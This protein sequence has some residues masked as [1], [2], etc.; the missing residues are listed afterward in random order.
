MCSVIFVRHFF[1]FFGFLLVKFIDIW[2]SISGFVHEVP[3]FLAKPQ[4]YMNL[5]GESVSD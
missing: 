4:T 5:S 1:F 3:V 2:Q